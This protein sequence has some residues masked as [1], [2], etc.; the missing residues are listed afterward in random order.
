MLRSWAVLLIPFWTVLCEGDSITL[1]CGVGPCYTSTPFLA[2]TV[3]SESFDVLGRSL[4]TIVSVEFTNGPLG[5][6]GGTFVPCLSVL[7]GGIGPSGGFGDARA[8]FEGVQVV[9]GPR[10]STCGNTSDFVA[11]NLIPFTFGDVGS[12]ALSLSV[13]AQGSRHGA[14]FASADFRGVEVFDVLG[15]P[16]PATVTIATPEP[17]LTW[18]LAAGILSCWGVSKRRS[19]G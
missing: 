10:T 14:G 13:V 12:Y 17:D 4:Q 6:T 7:G 5:I 1:N 11:G 3:S 15:N 9:G 18:A 8:A 2:Q 19:R 16:L